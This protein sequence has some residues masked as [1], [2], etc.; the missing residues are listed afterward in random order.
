MRFQSTSALHLTA[1]HLTVKSL[2]LLL[3][4]NKFFNSQPPEDLAGCVT[5]ETDPDGPQTF[6]SGEHGSKDTSTVLQGLAQL[7]RALS[8]PV[9]ER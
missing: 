8:S 1:P 7:Q 9:Q 3:L 4:F 5:W 2:I 6:G